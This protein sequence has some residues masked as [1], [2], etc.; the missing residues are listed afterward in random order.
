MTNKQKRSIVLY[1]LPITLN[2]A[3]RFNG[4]FKTFYMTKKA[5][6]AK[7]QMRGQ[8]GV[9]WKE[10]PLEVPVSVDVTTY[11]HNARKRDIDNT[12]KMTLDALNGIV[13]KDDSLIID[14]NTHKRVDRRNPRTVI[15]I[16]PALRYGIDTERS[17]QIRRCLQF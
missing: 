7:A 4:H 17:E 10:S 1:T 2:Q 13:W 3:Y 16:Q 9:Q 11:W 5:A 8:V 6:T 15:H 14:L 12:L